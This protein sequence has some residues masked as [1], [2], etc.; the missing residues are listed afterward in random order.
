MW[1]KKKAPPSPA[2][3]LREQLND[4]RL[5]RAEQAALREYHQAMEDMLVRRIER[6][7]KEIGDE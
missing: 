7:V 2:D 6:L 4:A 1:F 3:V 5:K